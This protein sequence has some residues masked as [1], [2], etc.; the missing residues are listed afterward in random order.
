IEEAIH[1]AN[2]TDFGLTGSVFSGTNEEAIGIAKQ[3]NSGGIN[4]NDCGL[5]PFLIGEGAE[6]TSFNYSGLGGSRSG[7]AFILRFTQ[8]K[9]L[10]SNNLLEDSPWWYNV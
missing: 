1:L 10:F 3:I 4:I 8:K 6:R 2:D 5:T 7:K 9:A